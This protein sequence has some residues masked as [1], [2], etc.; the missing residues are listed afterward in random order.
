MTCSLAAVEVGKI[1]SRL[2]SVVAIF[3]MAVSMESYHQHSVIMMAL[4]S[5]LCKCMI[6]FVMR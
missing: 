6:M 2:S 3:T 5:G 1:V 4:V